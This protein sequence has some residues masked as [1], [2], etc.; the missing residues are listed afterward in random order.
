MDYKDTLERS[1]YSLEEVM[2]KFLTTGA[3]IIR[4]R[5]QA[6]GYLS[7]SDNVTKSKAQ[8]V[9]AK[10]T[11][12]LANFKSIQLSGM[13]ALSKA[14]TLKTKMD[15]D[16]LWKNI[17]SAPLDNFGYET[18]KQAKLMFGQVTSLAADLYTIQQ[19]MGKHMTDVSNLQSDVVALDKFAQGKGIASLLSKTTSFYG[20]Y[21]TKVGVVF[22]VVAAVVLLGPG[23]IKRTLSK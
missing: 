3:E 2:G 14:N 6:S 10:A 4:Q 15:T 16:P 18:L 23:A 19:R 1:I 9:V 13:D 5:D 21:I 17:L 7:V 20:D 12:L 8:A 11:G 22:A